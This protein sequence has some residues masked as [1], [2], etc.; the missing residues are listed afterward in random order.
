[1]LTTL[2]TVLP[3]RDRA[4]GRIGLPRSCGGRRLSDGG[5]RV[6]RARPR[7][8]LSR[9]ST[10][11]RQSPAVVEQT[12]PVE[13]RAR[14]L[15]ATRQMNHPG[16]DQHPANPNRCRCT[17]PDGRSSL[18]DRS[19]LAC[20]GKYTGQVGRK[21]VSQLSSLLVSHGM[22]SGNRRSARGGQA[23]PR[24][25]QS[26]VPRAVAER[27]SAHAEEPREKWRRSDRRQ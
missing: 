5:G 16:S 6:Q 4:S 10:A 18:R 22:P 3:G 20:G 11:A 1:V 17:D 24:A 2:S 23:L 9:N 27:A 25:S 7:T 15:D 12:R 19:H 26:A 14:Q 21:R 8:Q 13:L